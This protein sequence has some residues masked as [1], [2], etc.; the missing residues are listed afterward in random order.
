MKLELDL[1][2][3]TVPH[4]D[5]QVPQNVTLNLNLRP[6]LGLIQFDLQNLEFDNAA[7]LEKFLSDYFETLKSYPYQSSEI[8]ISAANLKI[9]AKSKTICQL[10]RQYFAD[11]QIILLNL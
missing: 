10:I 7:L 8:Y 2:I 6:Q 4:K 1:T 11:N 5:Y 3:S 9:I